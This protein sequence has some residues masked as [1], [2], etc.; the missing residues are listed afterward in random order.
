MLT[1]LF[2][3][4]CLLV[5]VYWFVICLLVNLLFELLVYV[6]RVVVT[7]LFVLVAV[8]DVWLVGLWWLL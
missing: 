6:L 8:N 5:F 4:V 7:L 2:L 1:G 3:F